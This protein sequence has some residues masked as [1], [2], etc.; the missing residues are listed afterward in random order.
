MIGSLF[1]NLAAIAS[2]VV[3]LLIIAALAI[4]WNRHR[5][6]WLIVAIVAE[7]VGLAFRAAVA[8]MPDLVRTMPM[9]FSLW[10]LSALVF[11]V[12]LLAYAIEINQRADR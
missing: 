10:S 2:V 9:V 12:G 7:I 6:I 5:S 1:A 11:A 3:S 4:L 8:V